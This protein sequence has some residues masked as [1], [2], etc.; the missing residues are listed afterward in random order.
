MS[1][2]NYT[3]SKAYRYAKLKDVLYLVSASHVKNIHIDNGEAYID[4]LSET[5]TR[6]NGFNISFTE[7]ESLDERY[8]FQKTITISM[9]GYMDVNSLNDKYYAII[10]TVDGT[11]YMVNVDF[12]SRVTHTFRLSNGVNQ[13][14]FTFSSLSNYPTLRL[15]S[16]I[17]ATDFE[18]V[19]YNHPGKIALQLID[20]NYVRISQHKNKI[21]T[22]GDT[23][24]DIHFI[25]NTCSLTE[26][27][28]G[29]KVTD[30]I[31]FDIHLDDY[32][33]S[34]HYNLLEFLENLYS[35]IISVENSSEKYYTGF[36]MGLIPQFSIKGS[37]TNDSDII[38]LTLVEA[39]ERGMIV[40]STISG[41]SSSDTTW[42]YVKNV[43]YVKGYICVD[44]NTAQYLL[45]QEVDGV[46]NP[47]GRYKAYV[48][49]E[50]DFPMLNIVG[51]FSE[52]ETFYT[53]ECGGG[54]CTLTTSM[55]NTIFFDAVECES[56]TLSATCN[57]SITN[58]PSYITVQPSSGNAGSVY[59]VQVCNTKTPTN[60]AVTG[61]FKINFGQSAK[62]VNVV[63]QKEDG[64]IRPPKQYITCLGQD[65][66]FSYDSSCPITITSIAPELQYTANGGI[67]TVTVPKNNLTASQKVWTI[68]A[69]DCN[70]VTQT[71]Y[72]IQDK[73]YE[74][75]VAT[76][77]FECASGNSYVQE[78]RYTG[79][80]ADNITTPVFPMEYRRGDLIMED[81]PRCQQRLTRWQFNDN[82]YCI[83][84]NKIKALE[85][86]ESFDGG[87]TWRKTGLTQLGETVESASTWCETTPS[88]KWELNSGKTQCGDGQIITYT[89]TYCNGQKFMFEDVPASGGTYNY[90]ITSLANTSAQTFTVLSACT[91]LSVSA[92]TSGFN[93][94]VSENEDP[95]N[96]RECYIALKQKDSGNIVTLNVI[97]KAGSLSCEP[98][99]DRCCGRGYTPDYDIQLGSGA[100]SEDSD[101]IFGGCSVRITNTLPSWLNVTVSNPSSVTYTTTE[102]CIGQSRYFTV[103]YEKTSGSSAYCDTATVVVKQLGGA[104]PSTN[105]FHW[106]NGTV[107][108]DFAPSAD[109]GTTAFTLTSTIDGVQTGYTVS[110]DCNWITATTAAT[111]VTIQYAQNS[112]ENSRTCRITF[113]QDT[114]HQTMT[115]VVN[116]AAGE[117]G[118]TYFRWGD[119][120]HMYEYS[121]TTTYNGTLGL[122]PF[123]S[124]V[125]GANTNAVLSTNVNWIQTFN[126]LYYNYN[127]VQPNRNETIYLDTNYTE[128]PRT[129]IL[130]L[131]QKTTGYVIRVYITQAAYVADC[132]ITSFSIDD[133]VCI[134]QG[135]N[136]TY[137][138]ADTRCSRTYYFN[139]WQRLT[140]VVST[141]TP[142]GGVGT[143]VFQTSTLSA[144]TASAT[145]V[146]N[147]SQLVL[148]S[149]IV[150]CSNPSVYFHFYNN[151]NNTI[152]IQEVTINFSDNTSYSWNNVSEEIFSHQ[153][154]ST[155]MYLPITYVGKTVSSIAVDNFTVTFSGM[156]VL[157]QDNDCTVTI[158]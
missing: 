126:Q 33:T 86:E 73:T 9:R 37:S 120:L 74:A 122:V 78:M 101:Y 66:T 88:Y 27:Y 90:C 157:N 42:R 20:K 149:N 49:H 68:V 146:V 89:F 124:K 19:G 26:E 75:W 36:N 103:E 63:V 117:Q 65:V 18:C 55:P 25:G 123:L 13:T 50:N 15:A 32:K 131:T 43:G 97:Q 21:T 61:N 11:L 57:W 64:F 127:E 109:S 102:A 40:S 30:T 59:T 84:G 151:T 106:T 125:N 130:T 91:W 14:D 104:P 133:E 111:S 156:T 155:R 96:D 113:T 1:V 81:D 112:T 115:L 10:E 92:G 3:P 77:Q 85:Q 121:A 116:Q 35:S 22:Y 58:K 128:S 56:Y 134:G 139:L 83:N 24:K 38:T 119:D 72:I 154:E 34:W 82:Y 143:G 46:G 129:G 53:T 150:Q 31:Q 62:M 23:W 152:D 100:G 138:V 17:S 70:N 69:K 147:G 39:S 28:D 142:V 44:T 132:T 99:L 87:T 93:V 136:Y 67:L 137:T 4:D 51:T 48:G 52:V 108:K 105:V 7:E 8:K 140:R 54:D 153:T 145:C 5:P 2:S 95:D 29:S 158:S 80:T 135:L 148:T 107:Y 41:D 79:T 60:E 144:G 6:L 71:V 76:S 16:S 12:P 98:L 141:S 45:Q 118:E 114:S 110:H 94:N 47:T